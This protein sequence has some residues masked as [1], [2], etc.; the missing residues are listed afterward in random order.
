MP[1]EDPPHASSSRS[2]GATGGIAKVLPVNAQRK[3]GKSDVFY[4]PAQANWPVDSAQGH[5]Q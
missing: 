2:S 3:D 5:L 1:Y 4:N